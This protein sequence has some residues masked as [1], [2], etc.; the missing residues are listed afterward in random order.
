[1]KK[2]MSL[3]FSLISLL[4]NASPPLLVVEVVVDQLRGDLLQQYQDKFSSNGFN[5]LFAHGINFQNTYHVHANTVTCVGHATLATGTDPVFHGIIANSWFNRETQKTES[6]VKD[7]KSKILPTIH[8]KKPMTGRSPQNLMASTLSD[9]I[10]LA[11][12][13][14][15]FGISYKDRAAI[16]LAG[17][18]GKAFWFDKKNGGFI[19][20]TYYYSAYPSWVVDWNKHYSPQ[21]ETWS[22]SNKITSYRFKEFQQNFPHHTGEPTE[23]SYFEILEAMPK[24]DELTGDFAIKLLQ[25]EKLGTNN[26][27]T[28]YLAISFSAVD[29][30][31]HEFGPNSLE[32][33]DNLIRLDNTIAKLLQ[34]VDNQVGLKNTLIV[35]TADHGVA[36]SSPYLKANHF[37]TASPLTLKDL[38]MLI[39][40]TLAEKFNLPE[41][42]IQ[43]IELPYIYLNHALIGEQ[44]VAYQDVTDKLLSILRQQKGIFQA[45][46]LPVNYTSQDWLSDKVNRMVF[47][48]RAGDLY[49]VFPPNTLVPDQTDIDHGSPW[50]YDS[51]VPLLFAHPAFQPKRI[52]KL[53]KTTDIA[54]TLAALLQITAPSAAFGQPLKEVTQYF[55]SETTP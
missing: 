31:G 34:A 16:I 39:A 1:M 5:Y 27:Q 45:Y 15:A 3:F 12:K 26:K 49:L 30:V 2:I 48:N 23:P 47:L 25:E 7:L 43:S 32:S 17:H 24:I 35:L 14:R 22:L 13:G 19:T 36:N 52:M 44:H 54:P 11:K 53:T 6:C 46:S 51:Y 10:V 38:R 40:N 21:N 50:Q 20:S 41:E 42:T 4:A 28:D 33:E 37:K 55:A 8:T 18:A 9:E 29:G